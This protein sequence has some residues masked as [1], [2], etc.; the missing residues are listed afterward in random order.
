[1]RITT[2]AD[3]NIG[4]IC[5]LK[6]KFCYDLDT[7]NAKKGPSIDKLRA[8]VAFLKKKG[9]DTID[10]TGGEATLRPDLTDIIKMIR[11]EFGISNI[12]I[13]TNGFKLAD[14]FYM[15]GIVNAGV[16]E[17][18]FSIQGASAELHDRTVEIK[19]SFDRVMKALEQ[20]CQLG[21]TV[22][23]NTT[24]TSYNYDK[25][26]DIAGLISRY[27]IK[28]YNLIMF[29]PLLDAA[30]RSHEMMVQYSVAAP[31]LKKTINEYRE[32]IEHIYVKLMPVC[33]M[34]GYEK[35]VINMAQ[36]SYT[37]FDWDFCLRSRRRKGALLYWLGT[38][39]GFLLFTEP[40]GLWKR[41][42]KEVLRDSF[43]N[44]QEAINKY[45]PSSCKSCKFSPIC[46]GVWREYDQ[47]FGVKELVPV[48]GKKV[49]RPYDL[50][51]DFTA[52]D[53]L[54]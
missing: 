37:A 34:Q 20:A 40:R 1:M 50:L 12:C 48:Q 52:S 9:I 25:V 7:L 11:D 38:M 4:L 30:S 14:L 28:N 3:L 41:N 18:I 27:K 35:H 8:E 13:I 29:S 17:F 53:P 49:L 39:A 42:P 32:V 54:V 47:E 5:N 10:I 21:L 26:S 22:R 46:S 45:K 43:L 36:T 31:F 51:G 19:G 15:K 16:N 6:C 23:V 44:L 33:F 24:V 2:R